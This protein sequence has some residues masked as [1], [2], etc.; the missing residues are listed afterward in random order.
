M[1]QNRGVAAAFIRDLKAWGPGLLL[2]GGIGGLMVLFFG[3]ICPMVLLTGFPCPGCGLT[4]A[5]VLFFTGHFKESIQMHPIFLLIFTF[6]VI[7]LIFRYFIKKP[8]P[9]FKF[10]VILIALIMF[11]VYLYGMACYFPF[12]E[13]YV[14]YQDNYLHRLVTLSE[15][16]R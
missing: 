1:R 2:A 9:Y 11:G 6:F 15:T 3:K 13:P 4:R 12:R 8:F 5:G 10:Y 16:V 7:M 14:Y